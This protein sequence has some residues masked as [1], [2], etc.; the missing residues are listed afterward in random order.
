MQSSEK[1]AMAKTA[2]LQDAYR[3]VFDETNPQ[4][5]I[6]L[7]D[8][9]KRG[10]VFDSTFVR[11]DAHETSLNEGARRLILSVIRFIHRDINQTQRIINEHYQNPFG[12]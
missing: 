5:Q 10:F 3:A 7:A 8:L 9:C 4:S 2:R 6:V 11:G 12:T 1:D